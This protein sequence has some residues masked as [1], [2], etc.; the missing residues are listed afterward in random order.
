MAIKEAL[1]RNSINT[2]VVSGNSSG[3]DYE[4]LNRLKKEARGMLEQAGIGQMLSELSRIIQPNFQDVMVDLYA[5]D[6]HDNIIST[7]S[8]I[9][10]DFKDAGY[11]IGGSRVRRA[12][13]IKVSAIPIDRTIFVNDEVLKEEEWANKERVEDAIVRAYRQPK[14]K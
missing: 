10:W 6:P 14:R 12:N 2:A 8:E 4:L 11:R 3:A 13:T 7:S 9:Q 1:G 5:D